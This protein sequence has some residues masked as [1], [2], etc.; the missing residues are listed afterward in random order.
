M[1]YTSYFFGTNLFYLYFRTFYTLKILSNSIRNIHVFR[2]RMFAK[3]EKK[4]TAKH[5][6]TLGHVL[7]Q[8]IPGFVL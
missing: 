5:D 8:V 4:V 3:W 6:P 7:S 1:Q 2:P